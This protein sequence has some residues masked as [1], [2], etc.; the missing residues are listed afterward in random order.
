MIIS[1]IASTIAAVFCVIALSISAPIASPVPAATSEAEKTVWDLER[2]YW[3]FVEANDLTSYRNL[4]HS[5]FLGWPSVSASPLHKDHITDWITSQTSA[6]RSFKLLNFKSAAIQS[7]STTVVACYW[8]S[9]KWIDKTGQGDERT[10]RVTHTWIK[11]GENWQII[12]G[13]SMPETKPTP[14]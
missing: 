3:H 13:M 8:V 1:K 14:K 10:V 4:W 11:N 12:G 2:S 9:Y 5:D 7:T 6:G